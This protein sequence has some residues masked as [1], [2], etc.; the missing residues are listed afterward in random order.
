V[1]LAAGSKK[2]TVIIWKEGDIHEGVVHLEK[3]KPHTKAIRR[4]EWNNVLPYRL[5]SGDR[6][7]LICVWDTEGNV[8]SFRFHKKKIKGL[9]WIDADTFA[10]CS[11]DGKIK[12]GSIGNDQYLHKFRHQVQCRMLHVVDCLLHD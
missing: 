2:G 9:V 7:G 8:K 4:L 11:V 5:A 3:K 6:D 1:F 12:I 10:S